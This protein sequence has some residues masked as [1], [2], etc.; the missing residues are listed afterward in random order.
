MATSA[1]HRWSDNRE[2]L[3][4]FVSAIFVLIGA[5]RD[6]V[7]GGL[8]QTVSPLFVAATAF[9]LCTAL[10][11]PV[12]FLRSR[13]SLIL[14]LRRPRE[15]L[16]VNLTSMIAYI[17]FLFALKLMEPTLVQILYSGIGP[18]SVL[19]IENRLSAAHR[20]TPISAL[21]RRVYT[22]LLAT[23]MFAAAIALLGYSGAGRQP[24]AVALGGIALAAGGGIMI[25]VTTMLCKNLNDAGVA[26]AALLALR[27]PLTAIAAAALEWLMPTGIRSA[28]PSLDAVISIAL[29]LIFTASYVNQ[30]AIS[31][32]SPLTIRAV[33][34]SG[35]VLIFLLQIVEGRLSTSPYTLAA[36]LLYAVAAIAAGVARQRA[37]PSKS[38]GG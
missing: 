34:A 21:E 33:L 19:W 14:L 1:T 26:P 3:G 15:L 28:P 23:L 27:F 11:L 20:R 12:A 9:T 35:P 30:L 17:G 38:I 10:L 24:I 13:D 8:V 18:L 31:L 5:T 32:A 4:F 37:I 25:S 2:A 29:M 22:G 6:V 36:S 16:W 7:L